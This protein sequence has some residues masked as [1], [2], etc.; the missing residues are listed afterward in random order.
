MDDH[1]RFSGTKYEKGNNTYNGNHY[2][3]KCGENCSKIRGVSELSKVTVKID[4]EPRS[5]GDSIYADRTPEWGIDGSPVI[6][7]Q[8][9]D[10]WKPGARD[11]ADRTG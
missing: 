7:P 8:S 4:F 11:R 9:G 3:L 6:E 5:A 1:V 10:R 2:N